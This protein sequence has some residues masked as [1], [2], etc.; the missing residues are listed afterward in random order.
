MTSEIKVEDWLKKWSSYETGEISRW[1]HWIEQTGFC[2]IRANVFLLPFL[3]RIMKY[4]EFKSLKVDWET[5]QML[6]KI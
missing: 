3:K 5:F 1:N 4:C 2:T 6:Q